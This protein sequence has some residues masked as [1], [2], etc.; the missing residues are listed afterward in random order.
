M[1]LLIVLPA[2]NEATRIGFVLM[3]I[4][5]LHPG[6]PVLVVNDASRDDTAAVVRS[7]PGVSLIDL[8]FWM[9]YGGALQT[10]YK[11]ALR[12]GYD[13]VIQMDA[14]GQHDPSSIGDL[15]KH[16]GDCDLVVGSRFLAGANRYRMSA[17]R[18]F[19]CVMLSWCA[20]LLT[21]M[22]I[23]DPTSGFQ[24]L[25][26]RALDVA[27][28]DLFPLDY[29]DVDV[30]ILM[31]RY[32]LRVKEIPVTM[33]SGDKEQGMHAGLQVWYY[34]LKM[35]LSMLVMRLRRA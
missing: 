33:H 14:D 5:E 21:G 18:R 20:W 17:V 30:L 25:S 26:R 23:T 31:H 9:G 19:G 7:H 2:R 22:K 16:L 13:A 1:R 3:K 24:A 27:V 10:A 4:A 28:Q 34:G 32:S 6:L 12:E 8:P 29:P 11:F 15:I 35:L